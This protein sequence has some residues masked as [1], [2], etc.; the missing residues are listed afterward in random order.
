EDVGEDAATQK[1]TNSSQVMTINGGVAKSASDKIFQHNGSGKMVIQNFCAQTFGKLYGS[2]GNCSK[3]YKRDVTVDN[4]VV[5]GGK[6][7]VGI[8]INYGDTVCF[9]RVYVGSLSFVICD[10]YTGNSSGA[11]PLHINNNTN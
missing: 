10:K 2:C 3:Q 11:E 5:T 4:V 6:V 8:N 9:T 7:V 1:G